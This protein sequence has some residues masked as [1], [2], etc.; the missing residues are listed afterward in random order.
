MLTEETAETL[1]GYGRANEYLKRERWERLARM[2]PEESRAIYS[3]LCAG[4]YG[5]VTAEE[6]AAVDRRRLATMLKVRRAM[7]AVARGLGYLDD[8]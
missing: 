2:T 5:R 6:L 4:Y 8:E 7:A 1:A 3:D